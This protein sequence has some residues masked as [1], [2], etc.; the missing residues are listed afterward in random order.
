MNRIKY[1][2]RRLKSL[3]YKNMIRTAKEIAKKNHK[4]SFFI[5]IDMIWCSIFY[6]SG[7]IDYYEFEFYL[8]NR[9]ERQTFI[10]GGIANS[11]IVKYNQKEFRH[12]F[13]DKVNFNKTF[14][15]YIG[16]DYLDIR[17]ASIEEVNAFLLR[18]EFFM[19]KAIDSLMGHGVE[20][21]ESKEIENVEAFVA[22]RLENRQFL[23]E[24]YF[25]QHPELS[26]L[27]PD[28][29]NTIRM[30]TFFDGKDVHILEGVLKLGNGGNLDNFGAGGMYTVLS[31]DGLVQYP[32]FDKNDIAY[33]QHPITH[34]D[35]IGFKI[36]LYEDVCELLDKAARVVPEIQYVGWD[37]AISA[38]K[39][40]LIEGNYNTGVFQMKP[41]LTGV[42]TGLLPKF[43][44]IIEL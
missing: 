43:S 14:K 34:Q 19:A 41:S 15:D 30:I 23:F 32:A 38:T 17:E 8:L 6:Q 33:K 18:H 9:K 21:F 40:V 37:V 11:I 24:E 12:L 5:F 3:D 27:Y 44:S 2:F 22:K 16:R 7:Y 35:L 1:Y 10:T 36:P 29:V 13:A 31:D 28:S 20:K 4:F 26:R 39:P 25:I 42:K